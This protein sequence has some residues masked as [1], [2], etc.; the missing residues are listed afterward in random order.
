MLTTALD[1]TPVLIPGSETDIVGPVPVGQE[2]SIAVL[3]FTNNDSAPRFLTL[4][5]KPTAGAGT[6]A[7]LELK[8]LSIPANSPYEHGPV[9]LAAGRRLSAL[10]DV[11]NK[12]NVVPHG[13]RTIL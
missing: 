6:D 10:S 11:A 1:I 5:N 3:R 2:F 4:W 8:T 9:I 7:E 12:I 13:W